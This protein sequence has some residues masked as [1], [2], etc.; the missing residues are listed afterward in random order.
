MRLTKEKSILTSKK[1]DSGLAFEIDKRDVVKLVQECWKHSFAKVETNRKAVLTRGW[2]PRTLSYNVLLHKEIAAT[3]NLSDTSTIVLSSSV[4]PS[5]L[6]TQDG[7]AGTLIERICL[8]YNEEANMNGASATEQK[9]KCQDAAKEQLEL[10]GKQVSSGL[11]VAS[12]RYRIDETVH[13]YVQRV[14]DKRREQEQ[15]GQQ[16]KREAYFKLKEKVEKVR[17]KGHSPDKWNSSDLAV[18]IQWFCCKGNAAIPNRR[19]KVSVLLGSLWS[20]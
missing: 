16:K 18:M 10:H 7:F 12:G 9:K 1:Y 5:T 13:G 6:N 19:P 3:K 2:D 11:L 15:L 20:R 17:E 8:K 4:D 14:E